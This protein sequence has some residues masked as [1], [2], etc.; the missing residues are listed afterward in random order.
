MNY[1]IA[2]ICF[3][4]A[5]YLLKILIDS[6]KLQNKAIEIAKKELETIEKL[7]FTLEKLIEKI[8]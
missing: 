7:I 1:V 2:L 3:C 6:K 4:F 8:N 5:F